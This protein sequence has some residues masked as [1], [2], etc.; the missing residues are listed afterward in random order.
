MA[1][2]DRLGEIAIHHI[3]SF[4]HRVLLCGGGFLLLFTRRPAGSKTVH[5]AVCAGS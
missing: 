3:T 1:D 4:A 5:A 2:V